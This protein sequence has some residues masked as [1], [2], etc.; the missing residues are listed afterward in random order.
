M[1]FLVYSY[2][3]YLQ[4]HAGWSIRTLFLLH[5]ACARQLYTPA[6]S[7]LG[8]ARVVLFVNILKIIFTLLYGP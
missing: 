3:L 5:F 2:V 6:T 7:L 8:G 4:V 1:L